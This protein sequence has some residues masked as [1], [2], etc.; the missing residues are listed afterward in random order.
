MYPASINVCFPLGLSAPLA[1]VLHLSEQPIAFRYRYLA[2]TERAVLED[3]KARTVLSN[4]PSDRFRARV[5]AEPADAL[6]CLVAQGT[7]QSKNV[8]ARQEHKEG[9]G[10]MGAR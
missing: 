3:I 1:A 10:A 5:G 2:L 4:L 9:G 8:E 6:P 7:P